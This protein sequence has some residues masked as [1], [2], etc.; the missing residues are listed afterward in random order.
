MLLADK[1]R[2]FLLPVYPF[3]NI[4]VVVLPSLA[5][6]GA[7]KIVLDWAKAE[8]KKGYRVE[9]A[10]LYKVES[11]WPVDKG[12]TL[13]RRPSSVS[14]ESFTESLCKRWKACSQPVSTHLIRDNLLKIFWHNGLRTIPTFHNGKD[15][16]KNDPSKWERKNVPSIIACSNSVRAEI[17]ACLNSNI[18]VSVVKHQASIS[19]RAV[20]EDA[21]DSVRKELGVS[22]DAMLIGSI[23]AFKKQK[24]YTRAIEI[25]ATCNKV[26]PTYLCILGGSINEESDAEMKAVIQLAESLGVLDKLLIQGFVNPIDKFL[27]AFDC[28][29]NTSKHEGYS[30][31]T[32]EALLAGLDVIGTDVNGQREIPIAGLELI[33]VEESNEVFAQRVLKRRIRE[34]LIPRPV[35]RG[36]RQWTPA[37]G[38]LP[39]S[40]KEIETLFVTANLNSGGAQ[41]SLVNLLKQCNAHK[42]SFA[43]AVCNGVT[44]GYFS[45]QLLRERIDAVHLSVDND[46]FTLATNVLMLV[47]KHAVSTV[48]LWNVDPK[49]KLLLGKFLPQSVRYIDVSPG[50]YA[51]QEMAEQ[52]EFQTLIDFSSDQYLARLD[53]IV[54]KHSQDLEGLQGVV[55]KCSVIQN[56]VEHLPQAYV[57][58][59]IN[60]FVVCG[61]I[62]PSKHIVKIIEAFKHFVRIYPLSRLTIYGQAESRDEEYLNDVLS[63]ANDYRIKFMGQCANLSAFTGSV[64]AVVVLGTNQGCPNTVL[65]AFAA[66]IPVIANDSG[67][68]CEFVRTGET[69]VLLSENASS[70]S[71]SRAMAALVKHPRRLGMSKKCREMVRKFNS[72]AKMYQSYAPLLFKN[73]TFCDSKEVPESMVITN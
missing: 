35:K 65:E 50:A 33:D 14:V 56:G 4:V 48:C 55:S 1:D 45:A 13:L 22:S 24:N 62:T 11:E 68:T 5:L 47:H 71:L 40:G 9:L 49:I 57:T 63:L 72:T 12:I 52:T 70:K 46:V 21:R 39:R 2:K 69:G 44:S 23:G 54:F 51:T 43:L 60:H 6:G 29:L 32:Q 17:I 25:L 59:I 38:W 7:E 26:R 31:A 10:V 34:N 19:K 16:W 18:P 61:R 64:S 28:V 27:A 41:R 67:G 36:D 8:Y 30:I 37:H 42:H 15:G 20:S 53:H 73:A 66:G 58:P 3:K